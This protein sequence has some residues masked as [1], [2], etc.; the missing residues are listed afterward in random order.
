MTLADKIQQWLDDEAIKPD[1][2]ILHEWVQIARRDEQ[3]AGLLHGHLR[4]LRDC[5]GYDGYAIA[6]PTPERLAEISAAL[7]KNPD[8]SA[9]MPT[10][11]AE[12]APPMDTRPVESGPVDV[13]IELGPDGEW[14][15]KADI[16]LTVGEHEYRFD[17]YR[18]G[19]LMAEGINVTAANYQAAVVRAQAVYPGDTLITRKPD[20]ALTVGDPK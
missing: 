12:T 19:V 9:P 11:G 20:D 7:A 6:G 2:W 17:R 14:Q 5:F 18:N 13:E 3:Y 8:P 15:R 16:P 10:T 4:Y 1:E